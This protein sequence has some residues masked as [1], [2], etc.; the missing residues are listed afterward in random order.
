M[1]R[2]LSYKLTPAQFYHTRR[3]NYALSWLINLFPEWQCVFRERKPCISCT[4]W[5]CVWYCFA[6]GNWT[7]TGSIM[8]VNASHLITPLFVQKLIE[9]DD[10]D[11]I[12][13]LGPYWSFVLGIHRWM[14]DWMPNRSVMG[15]VC[16]CYVIM[17]RWRHRGT[18]SEARFV[19]PFLNNSTHS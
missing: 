11:V 5:Y 18:E 3:F 19:Q 7:W 13:A 10:K 9:P 12:R 16:P 4:R 1:Q 15:K 2:I 8:T 17:E 14:G 6:P